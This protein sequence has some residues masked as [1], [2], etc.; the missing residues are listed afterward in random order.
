MVIEADVILLGQYTTEQ[1]LVPVMA[2]PPIV[3]SDISLA[4]WL[5]LIKFHSKAF[6][7]DFKSS[8]SVEI[9]LQ[10]LKE[11]QDDVRKHSTYKMSKGIRI[12][13]GFCC[14]VI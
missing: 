2:H 8:E 11:L 7:L 4:E 14:F 9:S 6:K 5:N 1:Q 10:K 12:L 3:K 13:Q